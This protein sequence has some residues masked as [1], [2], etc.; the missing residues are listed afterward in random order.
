M[1]RASYRFTPARNRTSSALTAR[2]AP[3]APSGRR[4]RQ[5]ARPA[6]ACRRSAHALEAPGRLVDAPVARSGDERRLARRSCGRRTAAAPRRRCC[7]SRANAIPLQTTLEAGAA[8]LRGVDG[9]LL[10]GE[11]ARRR[12]SAR[13]TAFPAPTR[14]GHGLVQVHDVVARQL[15]QFAGAPGRQRE[16]ACCPASPR[17]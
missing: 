14:L 10:V 12:R 16:R 7:R 3:A 6:C 8:V 17:S 11:P 1:T 9:Q 15:G 13:R 2:A 5:V 4:R